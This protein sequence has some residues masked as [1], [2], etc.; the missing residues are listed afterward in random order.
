LLKN[1]PID[2]AIQ[3]VV[4]RDIL[5]KRAAEMPDT[6]F[7][8]FGETSFT[9]QK[10]HDEVRRLAAGL[11]RLGVK[12]QEPVFVWLP[13]GREHTLIWFAINYI[14]AVFV[15]VNTAYRGGLL[16][17]VLRN[18]D[19][20][21]GVIH[22]GLMERLTTIDRSS[23]VKVV[24][25]GVEKST[26]NTPSD[27]TTMP[28]SDLATDQELQPLDRP[29]QPWDTQSIIYTSGTTGPSKGVLSSYRHLHTLA[30]GLTY[31]PDEIPFLDGSDRAFVVS[32][33]FHVSGTAPIYAMLSLGGS[34]AMPSGFST[35]TFWHE[36]TETKSTY[37]VLM[38]VMAA[39]LVK[40]ELE[41]PVDCP[42]RVVTI[43]PLTPDAIMFG[44]RF[45]IDVN[46]IYGM[47]ELA[48]PIHSNLNPTE[49]G[50]CGELRKGFDVR[51]VDENDCEVADGDTGELIVRADHPWTLNHGYQSNAEATARAWRQGWFHTGDSFRKIGNSFYFVDRLN[52]VIRRRGENISSVEIENELCAFPAVREAAAIAVRADEGED[53]V[54][55]AVSAVPGLTIDP[56]EL[57]AFL[58]DRVAYFMLPRYIRVLADLPKTPSGK[59]EKASVR[60]EGV[61]IG[62]WDRVSAGIKVSRDRLHE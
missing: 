25:V 5:I 50:I 60:A 6:T 51:I 59:V 58:Q 23:L 9:Y 24:V 49:P 33:L 39:F 11:Q 27:I 7:A 35:S 17:H 14:G 20:K 54:L 16:E 37:A 48:I 28:L 12:Q 41:P 1:I 30:M 26:H 15:S 21:I 3:D 38:G 4:L 10:F 62:T 46:T 52:D 29:I 45:K 53:E 43:V 2:H 22:A 34:I 42:L 44:T 18:S 40:Q 57:F 32:P 61:I 13:N 55:V 31:G 8:M 19:A 47:S 36:V 56:L